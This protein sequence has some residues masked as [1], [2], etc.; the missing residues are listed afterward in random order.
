MPDLPLQE[1]T[2]QL[3]SAVLGEKSPF[4]TLAVA[5][6]TQLVLGA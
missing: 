6:N 3:V 4:L 2:D 5:T 1:I